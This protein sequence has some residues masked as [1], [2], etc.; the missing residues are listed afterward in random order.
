[1]ITLAIRTILFDL[2]GTLIDTNPLILASFRHTLLKHT[3]RAYTDE[4][5][6]PFIG[7]PLIESLKD[8]DEDQ[9]E[10]MMHTYRTHNIANHEA[11]VKPYPTVIETIRKLHAEGFKL[12]IVTTK[13]TE[14]A[15]LGL[16]ITG[17]SQYFDVVI[18]LTEVEHAKPHPEP[19]L[20][21]LDAL[22]ETPID[23]LMI[24]DNHHDIEAGQNAGT[25]TAGVSWS[26]K[27]KETL[28]ALEPD[29]M[30]EALSDLL[31]IL[32]VE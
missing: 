22:G 16:D 26:I 28:A 18:G 15:R 25:K 6:F 30:L 7:P 31:T 10:A 8:V 1:M 21:A 9:A 24:G 2:D 5:I 32:E 12:A 17:L 14:T 27:G 3:G 19:V 23:A 11:Y 13:I 29:Y 20:K 4:E